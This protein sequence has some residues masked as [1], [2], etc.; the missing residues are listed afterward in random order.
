MTDREINSMLFRGVVVN[1]NDLASGTGQSIG[2]TMPDE[3]VEFH[4]AYQQRPVERFPHNYERDKFLHNRDRYIMMY[5]N[6][7]AYII[8]RCRNREEI[9][10]YQKPFDIA[11]PED[12]E[13]VIFIL[14]KL[15]R[16]F[17]DE[18][19]V[20]DKS[21]I[22]ETDLSNGMSSNRQRVYYEI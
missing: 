2:G 21:E 3:P 17:Y 11:F 20:E 15:I 16:K 12:S 22:Q 9:T 13:R 4:K 8:L 10:L 18:V 19:S 14:E 5:F 1:L 6:G 7:R